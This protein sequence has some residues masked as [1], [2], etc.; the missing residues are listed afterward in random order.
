EVSIENRE[1]LAAIFRQTRPS[2]VIGHHVEDL[3]PD[4]IAAGHLTRQAWYLSGLKRMAEQAG[5]AAAHRPRFLFHFLSHV[6]VEPTLVVNVTPVWERKLEVVR[7]YGSQL[8]PEGQQDRGQHFLFGADIEERMETKA[9][10]FGEKI[11]VGFGEPLVHQGPLP[12][13][14]GLVP[15][16]ATQRS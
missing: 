13:G 16:L 6:A 9:R 10:Y 14:H 15:W 5:A 2:V 7:C 12:I 1:A 4:H 8:Q 3:H 11:S